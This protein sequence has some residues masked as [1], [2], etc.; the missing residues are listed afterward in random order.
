[1]AG[2]GGA[3]AGMAAK[4][5]AVYGA[6]GQTGREIVKQ[7]LARGLSVRACCV[8]DPEKARRVLGAPEGLQVLQGELS[9]AADVAA[10]L[11]GA[12]FAISCVG[13][14][15][16]WTGGVRNYDRGYVHRFVKLLAAACQEHGVQR[17][18]CQGGAMN[19]NPA[20]PKSLWEG[21]QRA[22]NCMMRCLGMPF[23]LGL[24]P[25][26]ADNAAVAYYLHQEC[27]KLDFVFTMP[28]LIKNKP[29]AGALRVSTT[30]G[31]TVHYEDLARFTLDALEDPALSRQFV[32]L[33]YP[34][35]FG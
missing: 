18:I 33:A 7:A 20:H 3:A 15:H 27:R 22:V 19:A 2:G 12:G 4:V 23:L 34:G 16:F 25:V 29:S 10:G 17:L 14:P 21:W 11:E 32:Y 28:G 30:I 6:T 13:G 31:Q 26:I 9:S 35:L 1:M 5:L 24:H 8:R